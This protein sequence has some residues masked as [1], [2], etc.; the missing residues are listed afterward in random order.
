[1]TV[2]EQLAGLRQLCDKPELRNEG[3]TDFVVLPGIKATVAGTARVT[4]ALLCPGP[5]NGYSTRLFLSQPFPER[6]ANWSQWL[7]FGRNWHTWSWQSVPADI[8][9]IQ[10]V[11]EHLS[12]LR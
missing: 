4:D 10:M 2:E 6:G 3:G 1:M 8:P 11:L 5:H 9:W 12:A 7:I